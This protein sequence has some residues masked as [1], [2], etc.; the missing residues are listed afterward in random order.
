MS[1]Q[2]YVALQ[3][4]VTNKTVHIQK[5]F[6]TSIFFLWRFEPIPSYGLPLRGLVTIHIGHTTTGMTP[7]DE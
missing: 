5:Y 4:Y 7:L 6:V 2:A 1:P 3:A